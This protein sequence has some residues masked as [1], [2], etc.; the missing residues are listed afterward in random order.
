MLNFTSSKYTCFIKFSNVL[1]IKLSRLKGFKYDSN[2][3]NNLKQQQKKTP[4]FG[5]GRTRIISIINKF[6]FIFF[7]VNIGIYSRHTAVNSYTTSISTSE[8]SLRYHT[9]SIL[10]YHTPSTLRYHTP[11]YSGTT[12]L[13]YS[14]TTPLFYT[15]VPHPF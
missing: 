8:P 13:L 4:Q 10:R 2:L 1:F 3:L 14:G 15:Q 6:Y 11:S 12:P 7:N 9:P 5:N